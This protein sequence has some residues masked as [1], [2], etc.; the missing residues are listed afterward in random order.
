MSSQE[1]R[2]K[3]AAKFI[4]PRQRQP[5]FVRKAGPHADRPR[6][7]RRA[8]LAQAMDEWADEEYDTYDDN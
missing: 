8:E 6:V 7:S 5:D 2:N 1:R 3:R 4:K